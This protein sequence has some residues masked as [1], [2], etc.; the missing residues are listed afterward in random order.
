VAETIILPWKILKNPVLAYENWAIKDPCMIF[1]DNEFYLFFSAFFDDHGEERS[2][3]VSVRTK[4][5]IYFSKPD[6]IW[7]GRKEGWSGLCSPNISLCQGK[8]YLT[9]NSWGEIHPNGKKNTLFYAV[10]KDLVNWEKDIPLGM[11]V[12]KDE[13]AIDPA[14]TEFNGKW[15][16]CFKGLES[17]IVARAPS[18]DGPWQIVGTPDTGWLIGGEFIMID[19]CWYLAGTGRGLVPILSRMKGTGDKPEDWISYHP[20]LRLSFPLE[21]F[22]TCIRTHCFFLSDNRNQTGKYYALYVGAT[23]NISHLG[24]GNCKLAIAS[25]PDLVNWHVPPHEE[26]SAIERAV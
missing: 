13:R 18:I 23:E 21:H 6:F 9:Y 25:S 3:L 22:N 4:D 14:V 10:S 5:F 24:R 19:G 2:H 1:R 17:P 26:N 11:E 16:L 20:P 12:I 15:F 8:Y 7:D